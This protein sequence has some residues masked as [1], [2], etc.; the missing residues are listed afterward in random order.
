VYDISKDGK[1]NISAEYE[2]VKIFGKNYSHAKLTVGQLVEFSGVGIGSV[3]SIKMI[4][5][6]IPYIHDFEKDDD[7]PPIELLDKCPFCS[8]KLVKCNSKVTTTLKCV[9]V[10]CIGIKRSKMLHF[11]KTIGFKGI[12]EKKIEKIGEIGFGLM[13]L[14][15]EY[16]LKEELL[17]VLS[18]TTVRDFYIAIDRGG[19]VKVEKELEKTKL[20]NKKL[21]LVLPCLDLIEFEDEYEKEIVETIRKLNMKI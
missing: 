12:A 14:V 11:F 6:I 8:L 1:I 20:K 5:D 3:I 17:K 7:I 4:G 18:K 21:S 10:N 2:P 15:T 13:S 19:K 9:N 16:E